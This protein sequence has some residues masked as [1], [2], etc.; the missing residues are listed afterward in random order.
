MIITAKEGRFNKIH[1]NIDGEYLLTVDSDYWYSCGYINGD[2]I[3][4]RELAAFKDAAGSRR[5][6]NAGADL[7]SRREH[8]EKELYLK[9]SR[10]FEPEFVEAAISRLK[11]IGMVDDSRFARLFAAELYEKRG[12]GKRRIL[13]ELSLKGVDRNLAYDTV[14]EIVP[15]DEDNIQRIVDILEKKY[16][17]IG[18]D[19]KQRRR[20]WSALERMGYSGS[21]IRRA[22]NEFCESDFDSS[23]GW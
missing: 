17:N 1:V 4:E 13:Y 18:N 20:A 8:S 22:L 5:A 19:G 7:I 12:M 23:E 16:Y 2:E 14:E 11:E 15:E 10:K 9:L 6:F 21:D 3:D